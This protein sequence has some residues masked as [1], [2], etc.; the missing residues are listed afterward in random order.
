M[1]ES[2]GEPRSAV[3]AAFDLDKTLTRRDCVV[4][5][6]WRVGRFRLIPRLVVGSPRLVGAALRRDRDAVKAVLTRC[7]FR[8]RTADRVRALGDDFA[9]FVARNWLRDD[10]S[11]RLHWHRAQGHRVV[12]VSASYAPYVEPIGRRLGAD[13]VIATE[14]HVDADG[15]CS[16]RLAGANCRGPEKVRRLREW[17]DGRGDRSP[18]IY[19]Y[20]DS[21]GDAPMLAMADHS[22]LVTS[23]PIR[24]EPT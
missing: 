24:T 22:V 10:T 7:A 23:N 6:L 2:A 3:V 8:G 1:D 9:D 17:I 4:P 14:I 18:V 20:G 21:A 11:A 13:A 5:F 15:R 19:A 12:L 16:G